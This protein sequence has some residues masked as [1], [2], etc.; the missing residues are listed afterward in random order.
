MIGWVLE[1]ITTVDLGWSSPYGSYIFWLIVAFS[2]LWP[3]FEVLRSS[4]P[5]SETRQ[6]ICKDLEKNIL[7]VSEYPIYEIKVF[8]EPEHG[9]FV[10]FC[11]TYRN[12]VIAI[13][14]SESQELSI[15]GEDPE[16]SSYKVREILK[17]IKTPNSNILIEESFLGELVH[18]PELELLTAN[19]KIW[20]EHTDFVKCAWENISAK[21]GA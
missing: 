12:R 20:P 16:N 7:K 14:D 6:A 15:N 2:F 8:E 18:N 11:R 4:G 1:L 13:Y 17:I 5:S 3:L 10:Y 9:G 19:T 21:Y